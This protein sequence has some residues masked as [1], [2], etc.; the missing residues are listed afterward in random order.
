MTSGCSRSVVTRASTTIS[1][2]DSRTSAPVCAPAL[3]MTMFISWV[4][5]RS[6]TISLEMAWEAFMT[7]ARSSRSKVL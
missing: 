6:R 1:P 4:R 7:D 2:V 5:S 3:S